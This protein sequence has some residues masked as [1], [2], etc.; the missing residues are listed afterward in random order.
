LRG[1]VDETWDAQGKMANGVR[2]WCI[3]RHNGATIH[4]G[5]DWIGDH[6]LPLF[7]GAVPILA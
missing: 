7:E 2:L 6:G 1:Y 5:A 4:L 3:D